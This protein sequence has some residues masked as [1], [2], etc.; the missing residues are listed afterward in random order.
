MN[1][2]AEAMRLA[3]VEAL[4]P[5]D[6]LALEMSEAGSGSF[7][8]LA[9]E[10]VYDSRQIRIDEL[11]GKAWTPTL[12]L[13]TPDSS[14]NARGEFSGQD[15]MQATSMLEI[16]GEL[17]TTAKDSAGSFVDAAVASGDPEARLVL[18][19]MMAQVRQALF[20]SQRGRAL[21]KLVVKHVGSM[22]CETFGVPELGLRY[23]RMVM[24]ISAIVRD[25]DFSAADGALP[26]PCASLYAA[27][28]DASYAKAKLA[29]LA[30]A[31]SL[32]ATA[33]LQSIHITTGPVE[34]GPTLSGE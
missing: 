14:A 8:T 26:E 32:D 18:S 29:E 12:A 21:M 25:D 22:S 24:K 23:H 20:I 2:S 4:C 7:P 34:S 27:L 28:P 16:V 31:F 15:D 13:Y 3:A 19:A 33:P 9:R 6:A 30:A 10:R 17:A 1:L 11:D 5:S